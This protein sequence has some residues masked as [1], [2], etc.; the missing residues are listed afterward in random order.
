MPD[1]ADRFHSSALR[2]LIAGGP[3]NWVSTA[4]QWP[5]AVSRVAWRGTMLHAM[6]SQERTSFDPEALSAVLTAYGA[7]LRELGLSE[8]DDAGT[9]MIA[10]RLIEFACQ[11]ERD[12]ERLKTATLE[13][14][15]S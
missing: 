7:V 6:I 8:G 9:R 1:L 2:V 11:G 5:E 13:A 15:S 12:P 14:L 3:V 4:L 10:K